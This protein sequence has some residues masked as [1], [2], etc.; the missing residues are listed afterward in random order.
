MVL[1]LCGLVLLI[2]Y[3]TVSK[4]YDRYNSQ[5]LESNEFVETKG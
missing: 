3:R 4:D 1:L 5:E 2:L